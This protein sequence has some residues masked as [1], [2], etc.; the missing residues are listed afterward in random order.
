MHI[1]G[2]GEHSE[3]LGLGRSLQLP[4]TFSSSQPES[5]DELQQALEL[6]RQEFEEQKRLLAGESG[7]TVHVAHLIE[8]WR[9]QG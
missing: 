5:Q 3:L 9:I 4:S 6:S 1:P 8:K 2:A 7:D